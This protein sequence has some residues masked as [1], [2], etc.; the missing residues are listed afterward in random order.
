MSAIIK[1]YKERNTGPLGEVM[2]SVGRLGIIRD[3]S[4]PMYN[5]DII[6]RV[7]DSVISLTNPNNTWEDFRG[8]TLNVEVLP[9][10]TIVE[11]GSEI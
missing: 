3:T 11:Y 1:H 4:Y 9:A 10:G 2:N 8:N 7:Y 6:L 5:G